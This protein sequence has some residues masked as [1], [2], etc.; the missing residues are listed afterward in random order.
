M[1][2]VVMD[3]IREYWVEDGSAAIE[4]TMLGATEMG[5]GVKF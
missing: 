2:A 1:S 3:S 5:C 4:N